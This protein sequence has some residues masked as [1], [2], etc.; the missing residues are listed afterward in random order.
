MVV[1]AVSPS[2]LSL[3][4]CRADLLVREIFTSK[5]FSENVFSNGLPALRTEVLRDSGASA[6]F[7]FLQSDCVSC[8]VSFLLTENR[9]ADSCLQ[10]QARFL[11]D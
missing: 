10:K 7:F 1:V 4:K 5:S 8:F 3:F 6:G 9:C 2:K 11:T